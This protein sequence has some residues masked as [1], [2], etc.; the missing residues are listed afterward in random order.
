MKIFLYQKNGFA[1]INFIFKQTLGQ[2]YLNRTFVTSLSSQRSSWLWLWPKL[3]S[4][5]NSSQ[6]L[7]LPPKGGFGSNSLCVYIYWYIIQI[8]T[9]VYILSCFMPFLAY[10]N[11]K[12]ANGPISLFLY[13]RNGIKQDRIY[14][15]VIICF[16]SQSGHLKQLIT[17]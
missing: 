16:I 4:L 9:K 8:M 14:T 2:I 7:P 15:E 11:K 1:I 6:S 13:F 3:Y 12:R 5:N 17:R 10:R